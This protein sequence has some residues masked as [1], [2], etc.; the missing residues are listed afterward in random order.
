MGLIGIFAHRGSWLE[1]VS[2]LF[3]VAIVLL[4]AMPVHEYAHG[5]IATKLGDPT[6]R[7]QGRLTLNPKAHLDYFGI[8]SM[9]LVGFGAA[10]P[11]SVDSRYFEKPKRDMALVA[12]AGPVSNLI[13]GFIAVLLQVIITFVLGT[14]GIISHGYLEIVFTLIGYIMFYIAM[15]NINLAVFN[16]IPIPPLDGSKI[17]F[18]LLPDRFYWKIMRYERIF[19]FVLL[20]LIFFSG[21]FSNLLSSVIGSILNIFYFVAGLPFKLF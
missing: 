10:R 12:L 5:F 11:V 7:Y 9:I 1:I 8:L 16:F 14:V 4:I 19:Y 17:L 15:L 20:F 6:P 18:A 3:S 13:I 21:T 2:Y